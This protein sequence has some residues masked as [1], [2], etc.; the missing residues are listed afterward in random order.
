MHKI[1]SISLAMLMISATAF[2][3]TNKPVTNYLDVPGPIVFANNRYDLSWSTHP[4]A[5]YYKQEYVAKGEQLNRY[6]TMIMLDV[7]TGESNIKNIVAAKI[8]ELKKL[9]EGNPVVNYEVINNTATNEYLIDFLLT[10][11]APNGTISIAE[12][13]VYRYKT[14]KIK[15]GQQA[16]V[17][18]GVSTR[19]Y[20]AGIDQFFTSLKTSRKDLISKVASFNI[21]AVKL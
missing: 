9:K 5:G 4:A 12:R 2:A 13:N 15:P 8:A 18:F 11:N 20:G 16:I 1:Y 7:V 6:K 10:A 21:P 17:L 14:I 3:Q 19:A